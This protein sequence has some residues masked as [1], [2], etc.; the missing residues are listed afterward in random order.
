VTGDKRERARAFRPGAV[1]AGLVSTVLVLI[2]GVAFLGSTGNRVSGA[3]LQSPVFFGTYS[4][5]GNGGT[6]FEQKCRACHTIGGGRLVGPDLDGVAGRRDK[7]W[8]IGFIVTPDQVIASGDP[9]ATQL[10]KEYGTPMPN[11]GVSEHE[12]EDVLAYI[13][14]ESSDQAGPA[15]V[16]TTKVQPVLISE[17]TGG[18][19]ARGRDIFTGSVSLK[20][21]GAACISCHNIDG[22]AALGGGAVAKDLTA[23]YSNLGE[24]GLKAILETTPFPLMEAIYGPRPLEDGEVTQLIAFFGESAGAGQEA[25][26][27][28]AIIFLGIGIAGLLVIVILLQTIWRGRLSGVR[29]T[30]V[31]GG[32]K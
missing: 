3:T 13:E 9:A 20:N 24:S 1:W 25:S 14:A 6:I 15:E 32:S 18:D 16:K 31:K 17:G 5:N 12:A 22:I 2:L 4:Q 23:S 27:Q 30:L 11:L 26:D 28:S 29:Q 19:A 10:L 7:D 8:I 21:G